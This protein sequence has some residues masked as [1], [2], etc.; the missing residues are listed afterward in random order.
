MWS[1]QNMEDSSHD[2]CLLV[3]YHTGIHVWHWADIRMGDGFWI[4]KI[5]VLCESVKESFVHL[6]TKWIWWNSWLASLNRQMLTTR[7]NPTSAKTSHWSMLCNRS[8]RWPCWKKNQETKLETVLL[9][10]AVFMATSCLRIVPRYREILWDCL[11]KR[12]DV[13]GYSG[14]SSYR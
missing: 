14:Q 13:H 5:L 3:L 9:V 6:G 11:N 4:S 12:D 10:S 8:Q 7:G 2:T 1:L